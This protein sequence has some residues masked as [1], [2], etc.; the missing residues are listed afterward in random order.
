LTFK[1]KDKK[2]LCSDII[3]DVLDECRKE[4]KIIMVLNDENVDE[5]IGLD[6]TELDIVAAKKDTELDESLRYACDRKLKFRT[7]MAQNV[8]IFRLDY[9]L[10]VMKK[11]FGKYSIADPSGFRSKLK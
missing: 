6:M 4:R 2:V 8:S 11:V 3:W 1:N 10:R 5:Y 9:I 7:R